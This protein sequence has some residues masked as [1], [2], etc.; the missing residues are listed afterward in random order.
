[1][2]EY[3]FL[4]EVVRYDAAG[5]PHLIVPINLVRKNVIACVR[6]PPPALSRRLRG[7]PFRH[8]VLGDSCL[9]R[10]LVAVVIFCFDV[11]GI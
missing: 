2:A 10:N 6:P 1:M 3:D 9:P 7:S 4:G 5:M 11:A 8:I